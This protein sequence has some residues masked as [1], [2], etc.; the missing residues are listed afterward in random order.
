MKRF[1]IIIVA[2]LLAISCG[3]SSHD[4]EARISFTGDILM[5]IPVKSCALSH[6]RKET[7]RKGSLN[8]RGFDYLFDR[9]RVAFADSDIVVG[10]MEFPVAPPFE[11][12]P[13]VFNCYPEVLAALKKAGFTMMH[14]A[15]NHIL[16]QDEKGVVS[17]L[18]YVERAGLDALGVARNEKTARAGIVKEVGGMRIGFIGYTGYLN[19]GL[20]ARMNGYHLNWLFKTDELRRDILDMKKRC[21]YLVMVAHAGVEYDSLP[22]RKEVDLYRQCIDDGVDLVVGH[23]THLLQPAE[24][25]KAPDGREGYIFYS[26][27]NFISNQSTRAEA[28]YGGAPLTTRDSVVVHCMLVRS[29]G[30]PE[31]RFE[32]LPVYTINGIEPGTGLRAIQ[33]LSIPE[34]VCGLKKRLPGRDAKEKVDIERQLQSLYQKIKA[35]R[36]A[37]IRNGDIK[38]IKVRDGSSACK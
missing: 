22:G 14:M 3:C 30:R 6:D 34:E 35:I 33:T 24:L 29:G 8:N 23:H 15:N 11:S 28:F 1:P 19:R 5:H 32:L 31:V 16:D 36:R 2:A 25:H 21:D 26:I 27:G 4:R 37:V 9:I 17:S 10:N 7:G 18:A 12:R 38:G 13:Y 20:P